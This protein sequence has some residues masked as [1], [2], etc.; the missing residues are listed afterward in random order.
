MRIQDEQRP[1]LRDA[2]PPT[3][4][5]RRVLPLRSRFWLL[6]LCC[7]AGGAAAG[8]MRAGFNVVGVDIDPQ[9]RYPGL[10]IQADALLCDY[11]FLSLFDAIHASPP[12]QAYCTVNAAAKK[13]GKVYP[14]LVEPMRR[15]LIASGLPYI[16]ENVTTA[17]LRP[18]ICLSG[19]MFGLGV[20]RRRIFE[21][22]TTIRKPDEMRDVRAGRVIDGDY[23][24]VAGSG[25]QGSH[26]VTEWRKAMDI[27]W[28]AEHEIVEA[29]PP[30]YTEWI[31]R[32]LLRLL[33][34]DVYKAEQRC[35]DKAV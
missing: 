24:T 6:D 26:K 34:F 27:P 12:C 23:V 2:I 11:E 32:E 28:M 15:L 22:N 18:D 14:D 21:T 10:F 13:A 35:S 7:N 19:T 9:P 1:R 29:I 20:I 17:P 16:M 30:A 3:T 25:G 4:T 31:G 5:I 8:Y 33:A